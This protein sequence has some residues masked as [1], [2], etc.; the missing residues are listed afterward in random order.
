[1]P[2]RVPLDRP[3]HRERSPHRHRVPTDELDHGSDSRDEDADIG[4]H[5][6]VIDLA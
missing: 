6:I 4:S 3:D 1:V 5:V 2:L